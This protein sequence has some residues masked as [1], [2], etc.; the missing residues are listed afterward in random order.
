MPS[1]SVSLSVSF[2]GGN[3]V[4]SKVHLV[5]A[6]SLHVLTLCGPQD[7]FGQPTNVVVQQDAQEYF[8]LLCDRLENVL[9]GTTQ[10]KLLQQSMRGET[11]SQIVCKVRGRG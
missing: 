4:D 3:R 1:R 11:T 6:M 5:C 9:Q 2:D 10:E 7:E 8:N